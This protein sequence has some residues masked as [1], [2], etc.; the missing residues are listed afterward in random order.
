M[1]DVSMKKLNNK[2]LLVG[3][4]NNDEKVVEE[5]ATLTLDDLKMQIR[6]LLKSCMHKSD[7]VILIAD[8]TF[9]SQLAKL[10]AELKQEFKMI[11]LT[12]NEDTVLVSCVGASF[13]NE[14]IWLCL[15]KRIM[16]AIQKS[17]FKHWGHRE[18]R[19]LELDIIFGTIADDAMDGLKTTL[20]G[21]PRTKHDDGLLYKICKNKVIDIIKKQGDEVEINKEKILMNVADEPDEVNWE[22]TCDLFLGDILS[23]KEFEKFKA[24]TKEKYKIIA[25]V[26]EEKTSLNSNERKILLFKI[27]S[28]ES[29]EEIAEMLD[30]T[31]A[32]SSKSLH[33]RAMGKIRNFIQEKSIV[34]KT[35]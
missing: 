2:T 20:T 25:E 31:N 13:H 17:Y 32:D 22:E 14:N 21:K 1:Q 27:V 23:H 10:R 26:L 30:L 4:L 12:F 18:K 7:L 5:L 34:L 6:F 9:I 29:H 19:E 3:L 15:E 8:K 33:S 16:E 35:S 28:G 11:Q 24:Q